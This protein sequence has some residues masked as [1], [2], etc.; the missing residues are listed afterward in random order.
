[1]DTRK[2]LARAVHTLRGPGTQRVQ[3]AASRAV[4]P[5]QS[6]DMH[7]YAL[8][9]VQHEPSRFRGGATLP[10]GSARPQ[11]GSL[12]DPA[13]IAIAVDPVVER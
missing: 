7:R 11:F 5:G 10:P 8:V 1:M 13:A 2:D 9:L 6:E 3:S 12:V 4:N